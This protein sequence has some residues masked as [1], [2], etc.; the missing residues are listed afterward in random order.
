[1]SKQGASEV[2]QH[3]RMGDFQETTNPALTGI[4]GRCPRC[5]KGH[6]FAG[7]L[8]LAPCCEV[9]GLDYSFADPAD[10]PPFLQCPS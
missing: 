4:Q 3:E 5:Q 1:M 6:L 8:R 7:V 2:G 10:A 9:C